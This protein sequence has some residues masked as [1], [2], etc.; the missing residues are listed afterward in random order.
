MSKKIVYI[1]LLRSIDMS[2]IRADSMDCKIPLNVI[3]NLGSV[4]NIPY[5][6]SW[7]SP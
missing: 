4:V 3:Y 6:W 5:A 1:V 2:S 7:S